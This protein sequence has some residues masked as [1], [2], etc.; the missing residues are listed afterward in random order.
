MGAEQDLQ[1]A[2]EINPFLLSMNNAG[3]A[4]LKAQEIGLVENRITSL[5]AIAQ[6]LTKENKKVM[7]GARDTFS[8][9]AEINEWAAQNKM[10]T[11]FFLQITFLYFCV[12]VIALYFRQY[13]IFPNQV[14]YIIIGLGLVIVLGVLIN[15][16]SYT[17]M[18]RDKRYWNRRYIGLEDASLQAKLTCGA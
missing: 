1:A 5:S 7:S 2:G 3:K 15:R 11:L 17:S 18:S 4:S 14:V 13:G 12:V 6:D 9:Q 16:A 10:D 8:R